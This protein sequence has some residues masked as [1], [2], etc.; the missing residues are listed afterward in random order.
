MTPVSVQA[1]KVIKKQSNVEAF[2][3]LELTD[4]IKD[5]IQRHVKQQFE[6]L[7]TAAFLTIKGKTRGITFDL[8]L[9]N[10]NEGKPNKLFENPERTRICSRQMD[11]I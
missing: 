1:K 8:R 4:K 11:E 7:M 6:L 2:E 3:L 5:Q 10:K 9:N